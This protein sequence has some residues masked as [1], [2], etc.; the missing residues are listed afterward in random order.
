[1]AVNILS[2]LATCWAVA[3]LAITAF[4]IWAPGRHVWASQSATASIRSLSL[5][6]LAGVT[7]PL[8][9][10]AIL[11]FYAGLNLLHLFAAAEVD[12]IFD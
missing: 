12:S 6:I 1:M 10:A 2:M 11:L 4:L 8:W 7:F 9:G 3:A 5:R